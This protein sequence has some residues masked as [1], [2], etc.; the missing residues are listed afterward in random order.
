MLS[1]TCVSCSG[2]AS[3]SGRLASKSVPIATCGNSA[4]TSPFTCT[5]I[6]WMF[7]RRYVGSRCGVSSRLT[8]DC[9]RS[10]S[11]MITCVYSVSAARSSSRSRSC[12]A[13]RMPPSGFLISCARLRISSR[14]AC[15][16][17]CS[18][19][20][21]A[22]LSC[23]SMCRH[24]S[25]STAAIGLDRRNGAGKV[26]LRLAARRELELLLGVGRAG[27]DGFPD[28][29]GEVRR[30]GEDFVD[31]VPDQLSFGELEQIFRGRIRI[32]HASRAV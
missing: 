2:S 28:C 6:W 1:T 23:W 27:L 26:Q 18:R 12:A 4:C 15:C 29:R 11:P 3:N 19:S 16:C 25:S 7:V 13:P 10:A 17:S 5:R 21:R 24:S 20:S 31:H 32:G 9:R 8:S 30:V 22:I 14:F